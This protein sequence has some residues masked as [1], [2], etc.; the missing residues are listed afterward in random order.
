L[1]CR[2]YNNGVSIHLSKR[3][4]TLMLDKIEI[5]AGFSLEDL[6]QA[7]GRLELQALGRV[8]HGDM[9]PEKTP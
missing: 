9:P 1:I 7:L 3:S 2:P 8:K 4:H 5:D 6:L